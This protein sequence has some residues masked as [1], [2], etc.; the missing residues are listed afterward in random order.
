[1]KKLLTICSICVFLVS[2][3]SLLPEKEEKQTAVPAN[4]QKTEAPPVQ[5]T[6]APQAPPAVQQEEIHKKADLY[7]ENNELALSTIV[8][9]ANSD[10]KIRA[11]FNKY[12]E[13][14]TIYYLNNNNNGGI[15]MI[16]SDSDEETYKR[17]GIDFVEI[18]KNGEEKI[19]PLVNTSDE[20]SENDVWEFDEET[21]LPLRHVNYDSEGEI[22]Y[23]EFW[24]YSPDSQ[25]KYELKN[26]EGKTISLRKEIQDNESN[27]RIEHLVY[28]GDGKTK[29]NISANYEGPDITRLTY[30]NAE[31]PDESVIIVSQ[32]ENGEKIKET[33]YSS[34]YRVKNVYQAFYQDGKR[35]KIKIFDNENRELEEILSN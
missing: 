8:K 5:Q 35:V 27:L 30:Y 13:K 7:P 19:T 3:C 29:L 24:N 1:M 25:V 23:A 9:V 21:T 17:H 16:I 11:K 26:G 14:A 33:V 22:S 2:G 12:N 31:H 10:G 32:F 34:D 18:Q 15:F 6:S 28:D 20:N 4:V